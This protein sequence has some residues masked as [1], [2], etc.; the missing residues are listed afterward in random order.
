MIGLIFGDTNFP[1]EVL[2]KL[3][4]KKFKYLIID[5]SKNGSFK[6]TTILIEYL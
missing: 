4:K 6:K 1:K 3:D 5:L 2:K